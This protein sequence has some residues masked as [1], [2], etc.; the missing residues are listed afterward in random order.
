MAKGFWWQTNVFLAFVMQVPFAIEACQNFAQKGFFIACE[1][2]NL[3][4][5][6]YANAPMRILFPRKSA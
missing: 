3:A 5:L 2:R 6:G 1:K 4:S